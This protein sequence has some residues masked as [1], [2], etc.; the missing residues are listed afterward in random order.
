MG[1]ARGMF[2]GAKIQQGRPNYS[3]FVPVKYHGIRLRLQ[4]DEKAFSVKL[5]FCWMVNGVPAG[6][7]KISVCDHKTH[8]SGVTCGA[9]L[10]SLGRVMSLGTKNNNESK[11]Y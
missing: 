9:R 2:G 11:Q 6:K 10:F 4:D 3:L 1:N 8:T 7:L 5:S